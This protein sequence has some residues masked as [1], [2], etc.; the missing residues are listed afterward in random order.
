MK[1]TCRVS[2]KLSSSKPQILLDSIQRRMKDK[3]NFMLRAMYEGQGQ[4]FHAACISL[5]SARVLHSARVCCRKCATFVNVSPRAFCPGCVARNP[6]GEQ[7]SLFTFPT[8]P[9]VEKSEPGEAQ[10]RLLPTGG[11]TGFCRSVE[12]LII[13]LAQKSE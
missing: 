6:F 11:W 9:P 1:L 8:R 12:R 5:C 3:D 13:P 4:V 7:E 2:T 10:S